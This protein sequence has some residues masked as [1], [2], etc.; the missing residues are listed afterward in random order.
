MGKKHPII[1]AIEH[2]G[3]EAKLA[4]AAG[5]SQPA[6]NKAKKAARVSADLAIKI[7]SATQGAV[8]RW[9]LRPDL[10]DRPA[11]RAAQ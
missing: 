9:A 3:S 6:I 10:W 2:F 5:V 8:P 7:E 1:S 11:A 4:E